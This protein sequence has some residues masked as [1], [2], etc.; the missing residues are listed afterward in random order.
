MKQITP[1][2]EHDGADGTAGAFDEPFDQDAGGPT[3]AP[4]VPPLPSFMDW[5][6]LAI[7]AM[8]TAIGLAALW[9]EPDVGIVTLALFGSCLV[10]FAHNIWRKFRYRRLAGA[11]MV[12]VG[13]VPIRAGLVRPIG[14]GAWVATMGGLMAGFGG[15]YG[16]LFQWLSAGIALAGVTV[17]GLV[18]LGRFSG[19]F[20]RFD[21]AGLTIA[22]RGWQVLVPW[23][24]IT[25]IQQGSYHDNPMLFLQ[26]ADPGALLV[27]PAE[28]AGKA[29]ARMARNNSWMGAPFAIM[30]GEFGTDAPVLA[31]AV[32][33]Y[34][35]DHAARRTLVPALPGKA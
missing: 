18:A 12:V 19:R 13:G 24:S 21:P 6:L 1:G 33:T 10:L 23:D 32:A 34:V 17:L 22:E 14:I 20:L 3:M 28:A 5:L 31:G 26:V 4:W 7:G 16:P 35:Q 25:R 11:R 27:T 2:G 8:F 9:F 15:G 29:L 30:T